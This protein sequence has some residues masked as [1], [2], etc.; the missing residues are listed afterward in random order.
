[1]PKRKNDPLPR[2]RGR[3]PKPADAPPTT[4]SSNFNLPIGMKDRIRDAMAAMRLTGQ[5]SPK[6]MRDFVVAAIEEK[7]A[8]SAS[9]K[10]SR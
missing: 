7:I 3:P 2:G 5:E 8:R 1:M 10:P 6:T 4:E 9:R